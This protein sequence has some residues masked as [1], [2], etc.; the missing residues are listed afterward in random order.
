MD[1]SNEATVPPEDGGAKALTV[2]ELSSTVLATPP[3]GTPGVGGAVRR[4]RRGY[5]GRGWRDHPRA[6]GRAAR[7]P[8]MIDRRLAI[9]IA[10]LWDLK[11][12]HLRF[13][14]QIFGGSLLP[15][16]GRS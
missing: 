4:G 7:C 2:D 10:T 5:D 15:G 6:A 8:S 13:L 3:S 12:R 11:P 9:A 14:Q 1:P 16:V